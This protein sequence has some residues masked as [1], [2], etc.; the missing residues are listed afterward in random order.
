MFLLMELIGALGSVLILAV[1]SLLWKLA[2]HRR[3][4]R[5]LVCAQPFQLTR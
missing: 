5:D 3:R 1:S 2:A 4:F